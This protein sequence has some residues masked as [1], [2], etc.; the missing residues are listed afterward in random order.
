MK[1]RIPSRVVSTILLLAIAVSMLTVFTSA[2]VSAAEADPNIVLFYNR[3]FDE[4]WGLDNGLQLTPKSNKII[5]D[6]KRNE[7]MEYNYFFRITVAPDDN[8]AGTDGYA[9]LNITGASH[10]EKIGSVIEFDIMTETDLD[11]GRIMYAR[12][13]D[14]NFHISY[15]YTKNNKLYAFS[16]DESGYL[17][18]LDAKWWHVAIITDYDDSSL[19]TNKTR[20]TIVVSDDKGNGN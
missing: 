12:G 4:G 9:Q 3:A 14:S 18:D 10:T 15:L 13:K 6:S 5:L 8:G 1:R 16:E 7:M 2:A 20:V 17:C 19:A 11:L